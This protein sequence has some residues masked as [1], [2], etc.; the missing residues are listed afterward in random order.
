MK[1]HAHAVDQCCSLQDRDH[2]QIES[3]RFA[4]LQVVEDDQGDQRPDRD[5]YTEQDQQDVLSAER[6]EK[7]WFV[8]EQQHERDH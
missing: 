3:Q 5:V 4:A 6:R 7:R 2:R 8:P 1:Q